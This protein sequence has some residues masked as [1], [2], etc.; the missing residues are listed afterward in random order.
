MSDCIFCKLAN[1]DIPTEFLYEDDYAVAFRDLNPMAPVHVLVVPKA[2]HDNVIDGVSP[3][4]LA[5]MVAAVDAVAKSTG[6]DKTGFRV[7]MNTGADAGQVVNH[8]HMHVLGGK[9]LGDDFA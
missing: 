2:H 9:R 7:V 3:Q 5:S 4:E 1:G 6:I 8:L